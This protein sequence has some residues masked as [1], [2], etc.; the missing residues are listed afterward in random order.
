MNTVSLQGIISLFKW[1]VSLLGKFH[2]SNELLSHVDIIFQYYAMQHLSW[3]GRS[4]PNSCPL[5]LTGA[6]VPCE[7]MIYVVIYSTILICC[8][9]TFTP[10][11]FLFILIELL[12]LCV[13]VRMCYAVV[14]RYT[15]YLFIYSNHVYNFSYMYI[16]NLVAV[17]NLVGFFLLCFFTTVY[18]YTC[19]YSVCISN[20]N[21]V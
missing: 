5:S 21:C 12:I 2:C 4:W 3:W 20:S 10:I 18:M 19:M 7:C 16:W 13:R 8:T 1:I 6:Q 11:S 15:W 17:K 9:C 14:Q